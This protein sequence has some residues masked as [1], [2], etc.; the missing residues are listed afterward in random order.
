MTRP[1]VDT[2]ERDLARRQR[3]VTDLPMFSPVPSVVVKGAGQSA[4]KAAR[5]GKA[6]SAAKRH[7]L[8]LLLEAN[9]PMTR[10]EM[11]AATGWLRDS[12][13]G[14]TREACLLPDGHEDKLL[15]DGHR[16][17]ESLV[18]LARCHSLTYAEG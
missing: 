13:N 5:P 7:V 14:R 1:H 2:T 18:H 17:G 12:V 15:T 16:G 4:R 9:G 11:A 6:T 3:G 8:A 10:K